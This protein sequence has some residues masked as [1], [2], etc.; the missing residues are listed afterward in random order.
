MLRAEARVLIN[1]HD[2]DGIELDS[3][4]VTILYAALLL[5]TRL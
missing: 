5:R 3:I 2:K 4:I 1:L